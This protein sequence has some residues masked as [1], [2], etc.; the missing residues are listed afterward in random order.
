MEAQLLEVHLWE[1]QLLKVEARLKS[2][3]QQLKVQN[4]RS[5]IERYKLSASLMAESAMRIKW[6]IKEKKFTNKFAPH[7]KRDFRKI[8]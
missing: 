6:Q 5:T 3:V 8:L 7:R 2:E 4:Q 1:V